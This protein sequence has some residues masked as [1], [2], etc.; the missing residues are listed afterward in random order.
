MI[1][2]M[3]TCRA[4]YYMLI[5][6]EAECFWKNAVAHWRHFPLPPESMTY[7]EW[8]CRAL[9]QGCRVCGRDY[10]D[11][12][13]S[14]SEQGEGCSAPGRPRFLLG[15]VFCDKCFAGRV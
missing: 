3:L 10:N 14:D 2:V 12:M 9:M 8:V 4:H 11:G 15:Q 5:S 6:A 13:N 1:A 7:R